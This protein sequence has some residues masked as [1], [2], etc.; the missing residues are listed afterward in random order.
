MAKAIATAETVDVKIRGDK[1]LTIQEF[2]SFGFM[3]A[4][5]SIRKIVTRIRESGDLN[6]MFKGLWDAA[7]EE[8]GERKVNMQ[9][10]VE[11]LE[12]VM[13]AMGDDPEPLFTIIYLSVRD[14]KEG[15]FTIEDAHDILM[16]DLIPILKAIYDLNFTKLKKALT[17]AGLVKETPE[18]E[19]S[20]SP[21]TNSPATPS[22]P[23][24]TPVGN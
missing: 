18:E 20:P 1:T 17:K 13:G 16:E 22:E 19:P 14:P 23:S 12:M 2:S 5:G 8:G 4:V 21:S 10:L 7:E 9:Q 15:K 24:K 11:V 6:E 3:K